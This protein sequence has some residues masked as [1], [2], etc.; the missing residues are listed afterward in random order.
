M[1][2]HTLRARSCGQRILKRTTSLSCCAMVRPTNRYNMSP[3][4]I[5][6]TPPLGFWR[7]VNLPN[8]TELTIVVAV[9]ALDNCSPNLKSN[10]ASCTVSNTNLTCSVVMPDG[11]AAAPR[12]GV[13]QLVK[14]FFLSNSNGITGA[15]SMTHLGNSSPR[16]IGGGRL[17]DPATL[18]VSGRCLGQ[19]QRLPELNAHWRVHPSEPTKDLAHPSSAHSIR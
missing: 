9:S 10:C 14:N 15:N 17:L 18:R 2:G 19:D 11:P 8:R 3:A 16:R 4:T 5:L 12:L 1:M 13:L 7:V 6:R